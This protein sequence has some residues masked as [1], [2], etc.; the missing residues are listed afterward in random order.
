M[1]RAAASR[2]F[3]ATRNRFFWLG[4]AFRIARRIFVVLLLISFCSVTTARFLDLA[5]SSSSKKTCAKN[6]GSLGFAEDKQR[7]GVYWRYKGKSSVAAF[8]HRSCLPQFG[9]AP[10]SNKRMVLSACEVPGHARADRNRHRPLSPGGPSH[11]KCLVGV[12][13]ARYVHEK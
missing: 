13:N 9:R 12:R 5:M 10:P 11:H 7:A 1:A 3:M 8:N 2:R 6:Q 4:V